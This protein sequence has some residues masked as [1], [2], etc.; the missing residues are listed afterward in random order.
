MKPRNSTNEQSFKTLKSYSSEEVLA[1][2]GTTAFGVKTNKN[3]Y[4][5]IAALESSPI[6]EPFSKQ[7]WDSLI[8]DLEKDR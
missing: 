3:N 8:S 5:L 1:A 6:A 7:E 2:G 4:N